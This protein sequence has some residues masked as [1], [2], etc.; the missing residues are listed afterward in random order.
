MYP[1]MSATATKDERSSRSDND[2]SEQHYN[3]ELDIYS[4]DNSEKQKRRY[5]LQEARRGKKPTGAAS[6]FTQT[7]EG[8]SDKDQE[9]C[10]FQAV[11]P[12]ETVGSSDD[13]NVSLQARS[14][15]NTDKI[16]ESSGQAQHK[17]HKSP[18]DNGKQT[19]E[20]NRHSED[21]GD[22][23]RRR[24]SRPTYE[25]II[26]AGSMTEMGSITKTSSYPF[27]FEGALLAQPDAERTLAARQTQSAESG[28][29]AVGPTGIPVTDAAESVD[30]PHME[31]DTPREDDVHNVHSN[32][33]AVDHRSET[34]RTS[35]EWRQSSP[36]ASASDILGESQVERSTEPEI[37]DDGGRVEAH[38]SPGEAGN[39]G[40]FEAQHNEA[41]E[42]PIFEN[43]DSPTRRAI[44]PR[45]RSTAE[46]EALKTMEN[47]GLKTGECSYQPL[48]QPNQQGS[49]GLEQAVK[50]LQTPP[51][52]SDQ[53]GAA[54]PSTQ[55]IGPS[56]E[57]SQSGKKEMVHIKSPD[58]RRQQYRFE[59]NLHVGY[60]ALENF[61]V[62]PDVHWRTRTVEGPLLTP[63]WIETH[64]RG[65]R[66]WSMCLHADGFPLGVHTGVHAL[67]GL[68]HIGTDRRIARDE[69]R[70]VPLA[71]PDTEAC[72]RERYFH[73]F[74]GA[75][76][77]GHHGHDDAGPSG[78]E[79][80]HRSQSS[81]TQGSLHSNIA[82][83]CLSRFLNFVRQCWQPSSHAQDHPIPLGNLDHPG[84]PRS[85]G[86]PANTNASL[87][88]GGLSSPESS[89]EG[90]YIRTTAQVS[91]PRMAE[92]ARP[93]SINPFM[94]LGCA[95]ETFSFACL[96]TCSIIYVFSVH[97]DK[98]LSS[99]QLQAR[100]MPQI[101]T[102]TWL[103]ACN[104]SYH[105]DAPRSR[106]RFRS[107]TT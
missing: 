90:T 84:D 52:A 10:F 98:F 9:H 14:T 34:S 101:V 100:P 16:A 36:W 92:V 48:L 17:D 40:N 20:H 43:P 58:P 70:L 29:L 76:N 33:P 94:C 66:T 79:R 77:P 68:F 74:D 38:P 4:S 82:E 71:N 95:E 88:A 106:P 47:F 2:N 1:S 3:E 87:T 59:C 18:S 35:R 80:P 19:N 31:L 86:T 96:L 73:G 23:E 60:S 25:R 49:G 24:Y 5:K 91:K 62:G 45:T 22:N 50:R 102:T 39:N 67:S 97:G 61:G 26:E 64:P 54:E 44:E 105:F 72:R 42:R 89:A 69:M 56:A 37:S 104:E 12:T 8:S 55:A 51:E 75:Y 46:R 7:A 53:H 83:N 63:E 65:T 57:S 6:D 21:G 32:N 85:R 99:N 107:Y 27:S 81:I 93:L 78:Q 11:N 13:E 28:N 15:S 41:V 103:R 30:I